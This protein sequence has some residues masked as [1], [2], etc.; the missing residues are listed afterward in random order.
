MLISNSKP[1]YSDRAVRNSDARLAGFTL[2][3]VMVALFILSVTAAALSRV[4]TQATD[5]T[6]QLEIRQHAQWVAQKQMSL[7]LVGQEQDLDGQTQFGGYEYYWKVARA[8]TE[9]AKFQKVTVSVSLSDQTD[10]QLAELIGF[11]NEK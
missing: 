6:R 8:S 3:E 11:S 9:L 1:S 10:Y 2:L 7:I 5:S 4:A